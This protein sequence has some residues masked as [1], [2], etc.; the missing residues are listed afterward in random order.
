MEGSSEIT[1][2]LKSIQETFTSQNAEIIE[3]K[4]RLTSHLGEYKEEIDA[5]NLILQKKLTAISFSKALQIL[6][7]DEIHLLITIAQSKTKN[8][9]YR[10][11][12]KNSDPYDADS[13][14]KINLLESLNLI[15][16]HRDS[17]ASAVQ[18][19]ECL[20]PTDLLNQT[21]TIK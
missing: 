6:D 17:R 7:Q 10:K 20:V 11:G 4:N 19:F 15:M 2:I 12:F 14:Q 5:I 3:K 16:V 9:V 21:L 18:L 8:E 1:E 13:W